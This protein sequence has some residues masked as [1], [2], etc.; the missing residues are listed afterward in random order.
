MTYPLG[1]MSIKLFTNVTEQL[2]SHVQIVPF[3]RGE[4]TLNPR[5]VEAMQTLNKFRDVQFATNAD[6]LTEPNKEA[7]LEACTFVSVSLHAYQFPEDTNL[8]SFFY[9]ALGAGVK[10]Q[11]SI[12]DSLVK[13]K[14]RFARKW[15]RHVDRVRIYK[16]HSHDGFGSM[17][18][19]KKPTTP[20]NK[21][22]EDMVV[23][24]DGKVGLCN[25]DWNNGLLMGDL[26]K[27]SVEEVWDSPVYRLVRSLHNKG[28]RDYIQT[29]RYCMFE[30]NHVYGEIIKNAR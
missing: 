20:C 16:T 12:L 19:E 1:D 11:I 17:E 24:W 27:Q 22:F 10:T 30:A 18:D 3:Y 21:P 7:I 28:L 2:S 29:C 5:F 9:D 15:L 26:Y 14:N 6:Y 8:P 4:A 13:Q 23:Y 25:H